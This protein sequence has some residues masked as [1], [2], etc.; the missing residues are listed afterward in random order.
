VRTIIV[1]VQQEQTM[2]SGQPRGCGTTIR[3]SE[4]IET[5][6]WENNR[7]NLTGCD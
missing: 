7:A 5:E 1:V 6:L 4:S 2:S 3:G